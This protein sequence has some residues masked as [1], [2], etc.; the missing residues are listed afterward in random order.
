MK[1]LLNRIYSDYLMPSRLTEY[2]RL[3]LRA[4]CGIAHEAYDANLLDRFDLYISDRP[5]PVFYHP[6]APS[7]AFGRHRCICLLTHPAQWETNWR[8]GTHT[9]MR[10]LV[11][12]LTW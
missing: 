6:V 5:P 11:Q 8:A 4:R 12:G 1:T 9:N 7:A 3:V 2:D 10:R